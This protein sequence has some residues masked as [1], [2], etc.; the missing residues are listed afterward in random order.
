[1]VRL[2]TTRTDEDRQRF[3]KLAQHVWNA[4]EREAF[5]PEARLDLQTVRMG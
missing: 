1:M 2:E 4:I 3:V 5:F